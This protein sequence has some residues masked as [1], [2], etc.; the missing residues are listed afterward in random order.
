[1]ILASVR[2]TIT[3]SVILVSVGT[4][5]TIRTTVPLPQGPPRFG[6]YG[7]ALNSSTQL[8]YIP[9]VND[10]GQCQVAVLDTTSNSFTLVQI[11][12]GPPRTCAQGP[13]AVNPTTNRI[14]LYALDD[15]G[16]NVMIVMD[17]VTNAMNFVVLSIGNVV[18]VAINDATNQVYFPGIGNSGWVL[19]V[20]DGATGVTTTVP[21]S[22]GPPGFGARGVA[23]NAATNRI[24]LP[25]VDNLGECFIAVMDANTS[26]FTMA[27]LPTSPRFCAQ[28]FVAVNARTNTIYAPGFNDAGQCEVAIMSGASNTFALAQLPPGP[29]RFCSL[30][31]ATN[32]TTNRVYFPG[33]D[34]AGQ[35]HIAI[36]DSTNS[37][38][39]FDLPGSPDRLGPLGGSDGSYTES[40]DST[41]DQLYLLTIGDSDP[42][43]VTIIAL[44]AA[45]TP[46]GTNVTVSPQDASTG[47]TPVSLT[48]GTVVQSG[49]TTLKTTSSGP[50]PPAGF[51]LGQPPTYYNI[52]TTALYSAP[53]TICINYGGI[54]YKNPHNIAIWHYDSTISAWTKLGTSINAATT[55]ACAATP[56]LSPFVLFEASYAATVQQPINA[57]GSSI[58]NATRGVV[59][60]KFTLTLN[61]SPICTLPSATITVA[62][63]AGGTLGS[64]DEST[65]TM[66][67]D[68][69]SNFRIDSTSCQYVYNLASRSLGVGTYRADI[70]INGDVVG[71]AVFALK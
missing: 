38:T 56:S 65:Y 36:L 59:P 69:G 27:Q 24:Y 6:A 34:D 68:S 29:P 3:T 46:T 47:A 31:P 42:E 7:M 30:M 35:P 60:T 63:T 43:G 50:A 23:V 57:D 71:S 32:S 55:T 21:F 4:A 44:N 18:G 45:S 49:S 61:N 2:R 16:N 41:T 11:P 12:A 13:I 1:M 58:F 22:S 26:L 62:R 17:G 9:G 64:I 20:M 25:V 14:Y 10:A 19:G 39:L 66:S 48:F 37:F 70:L 15:S 52:S 5:Q 40:V 33:Y 67:A 51:K 54:S 28:G 8:A 53:I